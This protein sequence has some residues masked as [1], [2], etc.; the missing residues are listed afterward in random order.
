MAYWD[1]RRER[2][3][4]FVLADLEPGE[5]IRVVVPT[6]QTRR[7]PGLHVLTWP[8]AAYYGLVL[9][10][11][12]VVLVRC[13]PW[14]TPRAVAAA[15][16]RARAAVERYEPGHVWGKL[17]LHLDGTVVDLNV[18]RVARADTDLFVRAL[19]DPSDARSP[20]ARPPLRAVTSR[21]RNGSALRGSR[22]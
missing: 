11:R 1:K 8:L 22:L 18:H 14:S 13:N 12:R 21:P 7:A 3:A 17:T 9:T 20:A 5:E 2:V 19:D 16:P 6:S 4:G 10:D 15:V